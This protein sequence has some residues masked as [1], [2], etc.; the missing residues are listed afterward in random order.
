M[1]ANLTLQ[2]Q[3]EPDRNHPIPTIFQ[4]LPSR[5]VT[6]RPVFGGP[7]PSISLVGMSPNFAGLEEPD[8]TI[9]EAMVQHFG[10]ERAGEILQGF[11][12]GIDR[13]ETRLVVRRPDLSLTVN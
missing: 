13:I 8:P 7:G 4:S 5:Y 12:G 11:F 9:E 6:L 1:L 10:A 3:V 2:W